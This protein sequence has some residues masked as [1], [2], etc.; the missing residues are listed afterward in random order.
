MHYT[1][2]IVSPHS[3]IRLW[4][5]ISF[6]RAGNMMLVTPCCKIHTGVL[7]FAPMY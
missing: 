3:E 7:P 5:S 1:I 6:T 2:K 4:Q